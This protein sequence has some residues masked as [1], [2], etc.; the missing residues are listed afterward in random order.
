MKSRR[1]EEAIIVFSLR[2]KCERRLYKL[3]RQILID[4]V[5]GSTPGMNHPGIADDL[6]EK[7]NGTEVGDKLKDLL[8]IASKIEEYDYKMLELDKSVEEVR[9][10]KIGI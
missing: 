1:N 5:I 7:Y 4:G 3:I 9:N 8:E 10:D 6:I 2:H